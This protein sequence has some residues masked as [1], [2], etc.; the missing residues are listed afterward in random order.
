MLKTLV[1]ALALVFVSTGAADAG[2]LWKGD[3][4]TRTYPCNDRDG[5][6]S[7]TEAYVRSMEEGKAAYQALAESGGCILL[8]SPVGVILG[9]RL[10]WWTLSNGLEVE[11]W[12]TY[13]GGELFWGGYARDFGD[14]VTPYKPGDPDL[15]LSDGLDELDLELEP[16]SIGQAI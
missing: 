5:L 8:P 11:V 3:T 10:G 15:A 1:L 16:T 13:R 4:A 9:E 7:M 12:E 6:V 2:Y 14:H